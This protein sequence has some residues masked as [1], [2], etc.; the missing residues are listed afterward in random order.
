MVARNLGHKSRNLSM[1]LMS[2]SRGT[3][4]SQ[5]LHRP[6]LTKPLWSP[7]KFNSECQRVPTTPCLWTCFHHF[8]QVWE[9]VLWLHGQGSQ[10]L[11]TKAEAQPGSR[12]QLQ[13]R[14]SQVP[15]P[16]WR[17]GSAGLYLP[18]WRQM[19]WCDPLCLHTLWRWLVICAIFATK[20]GRISLKKKRE[21]IFIYWHVTLE[22]IMTSEPASVFHVSHTLPI[23]IW[24]F[25]PCFLH[26]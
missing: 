4:A 26:W 21:N 15:R 13:L 16:P 19:D 9:V 6:R 11:P 8:S 25:L 24:S 20:W 10:A 23:H 18:V 3:R 12:L 22:L 7:G 14:L 5:W 2:S 17:P 1:A